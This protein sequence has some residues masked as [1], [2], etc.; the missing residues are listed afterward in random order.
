MRRPAKY[1]TTIRNPG[2]AL[3][4]RNGI[5]SQIRI[6]A[7][8]SVPG[9]MSSRLSERVATARNCRGTS[10]ELLELAEAALDGVALLVASGV[11]GGRP[12][13]R[14][15]ARRWS[16]CQR[17]PSRAPRAPCP[18]LPCPFFWSSFTGMT[19]LIPR[20]R[21]QARLVAEEYALSAMARPG[22]VRGRPFPRRA[23]RIGSFSRMNCGQSPCWPG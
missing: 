5:A 15:R 10:A 2:P 21:R 14:P 6:E 20:P 8:S 18:P 11:E 23:M 3:V 19:A 16:A 9:K 4:L 22:W 13:D 17:R 12:P 7:T 1:V